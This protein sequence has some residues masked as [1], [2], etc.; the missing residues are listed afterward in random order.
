MAVRSALRAGHS[1]PPGRLMVLITV[2]GGVDPRVIVRNQYSQ[3]YATEYYKIDNIP[4]PLITI[5]KKKKP[6]H[7]NTTKPQEV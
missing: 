1:L 2:R 7:Q 4:Q 6:N 5:I 3:N